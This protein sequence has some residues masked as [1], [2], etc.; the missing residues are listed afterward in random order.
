MVFSVLAMALVSTVVSAPARAAEIDHGTLVTGSATTLVAEQVGDVH[1]YRLTLPSSTR[2]VVD[3]PPFGA[4]PTLAVQVTDEAD[5]S[6]LTTGYLGQDPNLSFSRR[7]FTVTSAATERSILIALTAVTTGS[8][9]FTARLGADIGPT[10]LAW[11]TPV[12]ITQTSAYQDHFLTLTGVPGRRLGL[13]VTNSTLSRGRIT[14]EADATTYGPVVTTVTAPSF[15]FDWPMTATTYTV[16]V[17]GG[18]PLGSLTLAATAIADIT[19]EVTYDVAETITFSSSLATYRKTLPVVDGAR[20]RLDV[21]ASTLPT[22]LESARVSVITGGVEKSLGSTSGAPYVLASSTLMSGT[23][24]QTVVIRPVGAGSMTLRWTAQPDYPLA[25][26]VWEVAQPLA[27]DEP[28]KARP[29][30]V[31]ID[32]TTLADPTLLP[33]VTVQVSDSTLGATAGGMAT[34]SG[35]ALTSRPE[36][37]GG[38]VSTVTGA[39]PFDITLDLTIATSWTVTVSPGHCTGSATVRFHRVQASRFPM[40]L[41]TDTVATVNPDT[42]ELTFAA[43]GGEAAGDAIVVRGV[44]L[45]TPDGSAYPAELIFEQDGVRTGPTQLP[46]DAAGLTFALPQG[47]DATRTWNVIVPTIA[48]GSGSV[49]IA[50]VQG[51]STSTQVTV[52][53]STQ[54]VVGSARDV[55][56]LTFTASAGRRVVVNASSSSPVQVRLLDAS[57]ATLAEPDVN[58]F[59]EQ[60]V[61]ASGGYRV[62][63]EPLA[64]QARVATATI[65]VRYAR[66]PV[67]NAPG[68]SVISWSA[69][70]NPRAE[71][72]MAKGQRLTVRATSATWSPLTSLVTGTVTGQRGLACSFELRSGEESFT[73]CPAVPV[74]GSYRITLDPSGSAA[75]SVRLTTALIRDLAVGTSLGTPIMLRFTEPGQVARLSLRLSRDTHLGWALA[76]PAG[77]SGTLAVTDAAGNYVASALTE[78]IGT[79]DPVLPAGSYTVTLDPDGVQTG[80][81]RLTLR[82]AP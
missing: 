75:G 38:T 54:V 31:T 16:H 12:T 70:G 1:T 45:Q 53:S 4:I 20:L 7:G 82:A 5:G 34:C 48:Q 68:T 35:V 59:L 33:R 24:T 49:R 17:A 77:F 64:Q 13:T 69:G 72:R 66:D 10:P 61:T 43:P 9:A 21:T 63:V 67:F 30:A 79:F 50:L 56:D 60:A 8:I 27:F 44:D 42:T 18:I 62:R 19:G 80:T 14:V 55:R 22:N 58:G 39:T 51:A 26:A 52:P 32:P 36:A 11:D 78:P 37:P 71:L 29:F 23:G 15:A 76:A 41:G 3:P 46:L 28:F 6:V 74:S 2:L 57:G 47:I 81:V 25:S 73:D 65:G 40:T